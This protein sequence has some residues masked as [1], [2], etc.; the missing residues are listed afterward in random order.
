SSREVVKK[1]SRNCPLCALQR[2]RGNFLNMKTAAKTVQFREALETEMAAYG[3]KLSQEALDGLG[4]YYEVLAAWNS[5]LHLVSFRSPGEFATRH[6]LESLSIL[7]YLPP[8]ARVAD[9]G[10]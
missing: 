1:Q 7:K 10:S 4:R 2:F 5:R 3:A 6:V 8:D 9:I